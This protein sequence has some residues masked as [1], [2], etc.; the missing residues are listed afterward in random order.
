MAQSPASPE[1]TGV[2]DEAR[3]LTALADVPGIAKA[4]VVVAPGSGASA[5][6]AT[7]S[8]KP[9]LPAPLCMGDALRIYVGLE[10]QRL[11]AAVLAYQPNLH[12]DLPGL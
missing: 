11:G 5:P 9:R 7:V 4:W 1:P 12:W 3:L 2:E 8:V 6:S 10:T